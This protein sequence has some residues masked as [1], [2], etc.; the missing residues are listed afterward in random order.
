MFKFIVTGF[1]YTCSPPRMAC[2]YLATCKHGNEH[3]KQGLQTQQPFVQFCNFW[4]F[5]L[6]SI[7]HKW[8]NCLS[9]LLAETNST[10]PSPAIRSYIESARAWSEHDQ[11]RQLRKKHM[12][13]WP[14]IMRNPADR[15]LHSTET[16]NKLKTKS[17]NKSNM[18]NAYQA[19]RGKIALPTT[20]RIPS[21]LFSPIVNVNLWNV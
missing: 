8:V 5:F 19:Q 21:H 6:K 4:F 12:L 10:R 15:E 9:C 2:W 16:E 14:E 1:A 3:V 13:K 11:K 7:I 20:F 18:T 17:G